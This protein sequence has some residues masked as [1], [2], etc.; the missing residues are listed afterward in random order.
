MVGGDG[1]KA[2]VSELNGFESRC[3]SLIVGGGFRVQ[4]AIADVVFQGIIDRDV[5]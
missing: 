3:S 2:T 5:M 1:W 4:S